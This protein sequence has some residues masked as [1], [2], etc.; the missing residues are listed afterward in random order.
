MS[1]KISA[2]AL[3]ALLI[4][5]ALALGHA[6]PARSAGD[7]SGD[8]TADNAGDTAS[9]N[10]NDGAGDNKDEPKDKAGEKEKACA[11]NEKPDWLSLDDALA[12][13]KKD[14]KPVMIMFYKDHCRQCEVL[15][16][17]GFNNPEIACYINKN[18]APALVNGDKHPKLLAQ[19]GVSIAPTVWFLKPSADEIDYFVGYVEPA[20]LKVI[21]AF[22]GDKIYEKKTF[23]EYMKDQA[24]E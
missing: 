20:D 15:K 11:D 5:L 16:E 22:I 1:K 3:A 7:P 8:N 6:G 18:I 14:D 23:E 24:S 10:A 4:A 2:A 17:K 9:D 21:L 13:G 19:Y 12:R